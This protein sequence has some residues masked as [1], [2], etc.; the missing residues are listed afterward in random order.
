MIFN[1]SSPI[2]ITLCERCIREPEKK[3]T[4]K[5]SS[6]QQEKKVLAT[7]CALTGE[8]AHNPLQQIPPPPS[9]SFTIEM[10]DD[11]DDDY[12]NFEEGDDIF[13]ESNSPLEFETPKNTPKEKSPM[14]EDKVSRT[15]S[16]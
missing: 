14:T 5:I 1:R 2:L 3:K 8:A 16:I 15:F 4:S 10:D 11:D 12:G 6:R 9:S 7:S 13:D